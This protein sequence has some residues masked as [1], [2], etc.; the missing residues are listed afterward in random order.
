MHRRDKA[1]TIFISL[2]MLFLMAN[3][4]SAI[5]KKG[6]REGMPSPTKPKGTR[7]AGAS[8]ESGMKETARKSATGP[9]LLAD[10]TIN[11]TPSDARTWLNDQEAE[12]RE[13][14]GSLR[15]RGLKPGA[16]TI[17]VRK[18]KYRDYS[19]TIMLEPRQSEVVSVVLV[20]LLGHINITPSVTGAVITVMNKENNMTLGPYTEKVSELEILAGSYQI[21]VTRNGYQDSVRD[22]NVK[23]AETIYLEPQLEPQ[24]VE[25]PALRRV[26]AMSLQ[27]YNEG[28]NV[29]VSLTGASGDTSGGLGTIEVG[30]LNGRSG[31]GTVNGALPGVPCRVDFVRLENIGEYSF[32]EPPAASNGWARVVVRLRPKDSKRPVRFAINWSSVQGLFMTGGGTSSASLTEDAVPVQKILP[33][34]P[35]AA[36]TSGVAGA[37][38]VKVEI[39]ERGDVLAAQAIEGP[40]L[41]RAAA[42]NAVRQWKFRPARRDGRPVRA[43]QTI[44]FN[45]NPQF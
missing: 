6:G 44:Q 32:S 2:I 13:Q 14:D 27:S 12:R 24:P 37:V 38:L 34:Y 3:V 36:R 15:F 31:A 7:S 16:F 21:S 19:R 4:S 28:K 20:P 1:S 8:T 23:S 40:N 42:E 45:F 43:T 35:P 5:Q 29:V 11:V 10:L 25:K 9:A 33:N 22:V 17:S 26:S 30:L 18:P 39:D 41:L